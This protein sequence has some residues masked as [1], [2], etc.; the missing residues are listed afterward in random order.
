M[1][2]V[3]M[4]ADFLWSGEVGHSLSHVMVSGGRSNKCQTGGPP[5]L[6]QL[7]VDFNCL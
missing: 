5:P 2:D 4:S 7:V 1:S 3:L 6:F